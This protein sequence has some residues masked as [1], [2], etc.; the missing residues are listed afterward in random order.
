MAVME[1]LE[2]LKLLAGAFPGAAV[3]MFRISPCVVELAG[4]GVAR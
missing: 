1:T 2:V 3:A 4:I